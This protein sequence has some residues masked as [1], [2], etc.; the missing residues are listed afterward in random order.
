MMDPAHT[1]DGLEPQRGGRR[2]TRV[3]LYV[4]LG[5]VALMVGAIGYTYHDRLERQ[6]AEAGREARA[7]EP[8]EPPPLRGAPDA[9][10]IPALRPPAP[11]ALAREP[12]PP[13]VPA[14]VAAATAPDAEV[15]EALRRAWERHDA[16]RARVEEEHRRALA[17]ALTA[18]T[19]VP[20]GKGGGGFAA[21]AGP[22]V[23]A[24]ATAV[25]LEALAGGS[26]G[27]GRSGGEGQG[28]AVDLSGPRDGPET[29]YLNETREPPRSVL[30]EGRRCHP[31]GDDRRRVQRPSR[32]AG[33]AGAS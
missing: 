11:E 18:E 21:L 14:V 23:G 13:A 6:R 20:A 32:H 16:E 33:G 3:P 4:A 5:L 17:S 9:G 25:G 1:P 22:Q 30:A 28:D 24:R 10:V 29:P 31:R 7:L 26:G 8:A 2:V 12:P 15:A 27:A 19:T